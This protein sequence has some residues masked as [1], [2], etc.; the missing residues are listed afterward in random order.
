MIYIFHCLKLLK[1]LLQ[2][3]LNMDNTQNLELQKKE[4]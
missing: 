1:S 4:T 2:K 3:G